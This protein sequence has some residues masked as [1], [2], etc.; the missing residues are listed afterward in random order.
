MQERSLLE[1]MN[2]MLTEHEI[3]VNNLEQ[4]IKEAKKKIREEKRKCKTKN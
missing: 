4:L 1:I 2:E 3:F